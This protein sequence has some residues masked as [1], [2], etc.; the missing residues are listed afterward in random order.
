MGLV[1]NI[2]VTHVALMSTNEERGSRAIQERIR[3]LC[4][5]GI[6]SIN[7]NYILMC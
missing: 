2:D 4:L 5:T 1:T 6:A 3:C 7:Q